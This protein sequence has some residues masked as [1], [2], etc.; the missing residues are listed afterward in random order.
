MIAMSGDL[1]R[2]NGG[3]PASIRNLALD[4]T[5]IAPTFFVTGNHEARSRSLP[6]LLQLLR[7]S[8]VRILECDSMV[9]SRGNGSIAVAGIGDPGRYSRHGIS[10]TES[11]EKWESDLSALRK[12]IQPGLYAVLLSH[13]PEFFGRYA[14]LGFDLVLSGH[15]HGG[16]VR[17][18]FIGAL[19][20]PGQGMFPALTSGMHR[21]G[22]TALVISRG[23][24]TSGIPVRMLNRPELVVV[25][26]RSQAEEPSSAEARTTR[27]LGTPIRLAI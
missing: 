13:R 10:W 14:E 4:L 19:Y 23:L 24:G 5:R 16:Q 8:G 20:A 25:R 17:L 27:T 7:S 12:K 9:L 18:P 6:E 1:I 26:L 15:A 21:Q 11:V 3:H 2:K 22:R